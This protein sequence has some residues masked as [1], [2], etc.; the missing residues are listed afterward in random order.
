MRKALHMTGQ[1]FKTGLLMQ[2]C[3]IY[4]AGSC[5]GDN[6]LCARSDLKRS[7]DLP[8]HAHPERAVA[9]LFR[10]I[11]IGTLELENRIVMPPMGIHWAED[12]VPSAD[13][14]RY[15]RQRAAGGAGLIV[16]EGTFID[17]PVSGHNPGYLRF[18]SEATVAGWTEVVRQVHEAGGKI[19]PE[20][21]HCGLVYPS[22]DIRD[23]TEYDPARGFLGPSGLIMPGQQVTQPMTQAEIDGV[24]ESFVRSSADAQRAGF[25]GIE[26]HGAHG[27]LLDQ[28]FWSELNLRTDQYG[29]SMRNRARFAAEIIAAVRSALGPD[30]PISIRISQWK[31]Q[32]FDA[33]IAHSPQELANWLEPLVDAGVDFFDCSQRRFWEAEFEES[34][35]TFAG[36]VKKITGRPVIAVGSVGL[37]MEMRDSLLSGKTAAPVSIER[38]IQLLETDE[39]DMVAIGR[40]LI[41]DAEWPQKV[42]AGQFDALVGFTPQVLKDTSP[43]YNY[44]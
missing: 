27:F 20:L 9:T 31:M 2:A 12:G 21:W 7:V 29:G 44:L 15:Y 17:H 26:I 35:L 23:G 41:A 28:F 40:S 6:P 39:F 3:A 38:L 16:T 11:T 25:D 10:P 30:M 34:P 1:T 32:D 43:T 24:I 4:F 13:V 22:E 8:N 18:N 14:A 5:S 19:I 42:A 36:W 33:K 37:D